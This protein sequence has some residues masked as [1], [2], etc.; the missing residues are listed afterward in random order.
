MEKKKCLHLLTMAIRHYLFMYLLMFT[1]LS[2]LSHKGIQ[3]AKS[4]QQNPNEIVLKELKIVPQRTDNYRTV[5]NRF[6]DILETDLS[7]SFNWG[8]HECLGTISIW[9]KP[10]FYESDSIELDAKAMVFHGVQILDQNKQEVLYTLHYNKSKLALKLERKFSAK[11]SVLLKIN[12]TAKP[13]EVEQTGSQAIKEGKGLYFIN[14]NHAD[15]HKP[16]QV[17]TQGETE[18]NSC[19]FPTI[20]KPNEKFLMRVSITVNNEL[21]TLS[22]GQLIS[23]IV[24]GNRRTD[25][26]KSKHPMPAYLVMLAVGNFT[27]T[28]DTLYTVVKDSVV[29][30]RYDTISLTVNDS[31]KRDSIVPIRAVKN[32]ETKVDVLNG[33]DVSYYLEENYTQYAKQIFKHTPE[34][35]DFFAA[36]L[37]VDYPWEKYA[38]VVVRD[39]VSGAMENTS[40]TIHG[41]FVQKNFREL[42]EKPN[43]DIIAHELFHQWFGDLVTCSSWSHLVLNEGFAVLGEQLWH[44]YKYGRDAGLWKQYNS[45]Q[46]YLRY[47]ENNVDEPIIQ[48]NYADKEDMFNAITYQKGARVLQLLRMEIGDDA[49]FKSLRNY[50]QQYSFSNADIDDFRKECEKVCGLDLRNFFSQW[51]YRGGHPKLELRYTKV[52][53]TKWMSIRIEQ[54]QDPALGVFQFPLTF[55]VRHG[56][57]VKYYTFSLRKKVETFYVAPLEEDRMDYP[58]ISVDPYCTFIGEIEDNKSIL[59]Q[60]ETYTYAS[61]AI[62]KVRSLTALQ[63]IQNSSDTAR[64]VLLTA[65]NDTDPSIRA[66]VVDWVNWEN[67]KN[68]QTAS[69]LLQHM[70]KNDPEASVRVQCAKAL[71]SFND[72]SLFNVLSDLSNDSLY[73]VAG[74][75]LQGIAKLLPLEAFRIA[76][77]VEKD[78]RGKLLESVSELLANYGDSSQYVFFEDKIAYFF[79]RSRSKLME[80]YTLFSTRL[81]QKE[82]YNRALE[83][84]TEKAQNESNTTCR[85]QAILSLHNILEALQQKNL[86]ANEAIDTNLLKS[87][88]QNIINQEKSSVVVDLLKLKGLQASSE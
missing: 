74:Y 50:L 8:K 68:K 55:K 10:Y 27:K 18:A 2:C 63:E 60:M 83:F 16:I 88:I 6:W 33:L 39:Y 20:D 3:T 61:N 77:G 49:F 65:L 28:S 4:N 85:Y 5:A 31:T 44:E 81:H 51:F 17:W 78:A 82:V 69:N 35:I 23:S 64:E 43:D 46:S 87:S 1:F 41:E 52:D 29:Q 15:A 67:E 84:F 72:P 62:E 75:A 58:L 14:T 26:W 37:G 59:Q 42:T 21:T 56:N 30:I 54:K 86:P 25:V 48:F 12:Y 9:M 38:Q 80:D 73:S 36:K 19:W 76:K 66:K 24:D 40:A 57:T 34:M 11:D 32:T 79:G 22:N 7:V 47:A 71:A 53:S 13:D 45:M 70:V